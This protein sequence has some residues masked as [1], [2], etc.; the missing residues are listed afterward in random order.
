M[1][2]MVLVTTDELCA[3]MKDVFEDTRSVLEPVVF[4]IS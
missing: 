1:D 2:E 4:L 3:A